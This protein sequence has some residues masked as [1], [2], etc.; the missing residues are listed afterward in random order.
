MIIEVKTILMALVATSP[1]I[2][3]YFRHLKRRKKLN[4]LGD[5]ELVVKP[6]SSLTK[7]MTVI[8]GTFAVLFFI[9]LFSMAYIEG[10]LDIARIVGSQTIMLASFAFMIYDYGKIFVGEKGIYGITKEVFLWDTIVKVEFDN[11]IKQTQYGVKF[12]MKDQKIPLKFYF[13]RTKIE[14]LKKIFEKKK[15]I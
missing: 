12:Y 1:L 6:K 15:I 8:I 9:I 2:Y 3:T 13:K 5:V 11:D 10:R 14:E 7:R 4:S